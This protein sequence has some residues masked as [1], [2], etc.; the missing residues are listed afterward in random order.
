[1]MSRMVGLLW[2]AVGS[3]SFANPPDSIAF[4]ENEIRPVLVQHC[5]KCHSAEA[6]EVGGALL[7]DSSVGMMSGGDSG[8]AIQPGDA[9]ASILISALRY[10]SME[11]PPDGKLPEEVINAFE[12][13]IDAGATD[14][15]TA[16]TA[17]VQ[18]SQIDLEQGRQFWAFRPLSDSSAP[19]SNHGSSRGIIDAYLN[20]QLLS[21]SLTANEL[22]PPATRLRRLA[23]D[24]TGL[25]PGLA[26]QEAWLADPSDQHWQRI[27]DSMLASPAFGEHWA[28]HW[29]D[30]ARY[31]DSNGSDFNATHHEAWR[32]RQYLIDSFANDRPFDQMIRQQ[33]AGDLLPATTVSERHDNLV[34]TT[35]L[36]IGAKMLSE[37]DKAKLTMDVVDE[38]IDTV[39][40]AFLGL[41]LG[42]ARCHDHKFDPVP[43]ED[44]YALAGIF[45]STVTLKGESQKYVSDWNRVPLPTSQQHRDAVNEHT[46]AKK[47]LQESIKLAEKT[48]KKLE[49]S[50][51]AKHAGIVVDDEQATKVGQW[52]SSKYFE[53]FV[54]VGY[55]HDDNGSKGENS[56]QFKTRL[57]QPGRYEVRLSHSPGSNRSSAA[58]VVIVTTQGEQMVSIDQRTVG[59][60]PMWSS[61]GT[62]EFSS[63]VDAVVTIT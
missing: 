37:R 39:G 26:L 38:Q 34:A 15:R 54:G 51:A 63:D 60:Q 42:C 16:T 55:V 56:I 14:P 12:K 45:K 36:M 1:M 22:A 52:K 28:R 29:M 33:I 31:A 53:H 3:V 9:K 2:W 8:P 59:I 18:Q 40:R 10:E 48:V 6:D 23:L 5:Y 50:G 62:F 19:N 25:P 30:V 44:Y 13:W 32:Y 27:V 20:E 41:T 47:S 7:L 57:P 21:A 61:L 43:T 58:P 24:L 46:S 35:F 11:M 4:F 17:P 49:K